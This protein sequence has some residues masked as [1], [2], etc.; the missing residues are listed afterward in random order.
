MAKV[1]KKSVFGSPSSVKE[2]PI[3]KTTRNVRKIVD[4]ETEQRRVKMARLRAARLEKEAGRPAK[5]IT[6]R[7]P[8]TSK[9]SPYTDVKKR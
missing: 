7:T 4:E 8:G 2:Q 5:T 1:T 9:G 6:T 3:D